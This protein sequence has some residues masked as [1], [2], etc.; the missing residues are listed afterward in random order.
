MSIPPK[1]T[2]MRYELMLITPEW[3]KDRLDIT[4]SLLHEGTFRQR[5]LREDSVNQ[6][7]NEMLNRNWKS[8]HQGIAIRESDCAVLDGRHRLTAL[9]KA[10]VS[11]WMWVAFYDD[12]AAMK[13]F[14]TGKLRTIAEILKIIGED[15]AT[16]KKT[17]V[18]KALVELAFQKQ[19]FKLTADTA[20]P[21]I[22]LMRRD[23]DSVISLC[24]S[25]DQ[26]SYTIAPIIVYHSFAPEKAFDFAQVFFSKNW[27]PGHPARALSIWLDNHA[28]YK[29]G[30][31]F[32]L[33]TMMT[34]ASALMHHAKAGKI[35]KIY[36]GKECMEWLTTEGHALLDQIKVITKGLFPDSAVNN[37]KGTK[38]AK[39]GVG[40]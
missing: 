10:G 24:K 6:Y 38:S 13:V 16:D 4:N 14:D 28:K 21:I 23:Y 36:G 15:G 29:G 19:R 5:S 12:D 26:T 18:A 27:S 30:G 37:T 34:V 39:R 8:T 33:L 31:S 7:Y 3:A 32:R 25:K 20:A 11:L 1:P 17:A 22:N 2:G 35:D 40:A 9:V